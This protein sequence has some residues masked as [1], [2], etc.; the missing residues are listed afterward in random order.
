MIDKCMHVGV[1]VGIIKLSMNEQG[2]V[3]KGPGDH[4]VL[5]HR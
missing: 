5:A 4:V 3:Y 2:R 1:Y